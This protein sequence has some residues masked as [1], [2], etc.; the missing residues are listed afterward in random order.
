MA[1]TPPETT[2][3]IDLSSNDRRTAACLIAWDEA[4]R[5]RVVA[6][7]RSLT[8]DDLRERIRDAGCAGIDAPFSW[9]LRFREQ[10]A[11]HHEHG[12]WEA[13]YRD[14]EFQFR[15]TDLFV[16]GCA[17][18]PLSVSTN[19]I[20]VTAMRC[21]R[22]LEE[23]GEER[24]R[25]IE[26]TGADGIFEVYPAAALAAWGAKD[27]GFDPDGYKTGPKANEKRRALAEAIF[28]AADW[29]EVA[30]DV[31]ERCIRSDDELDALIAALATRA[32]ARDL[33]RPPETDSQRA[34]APVEGWIHVPQPGSFGRLPH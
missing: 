32:A 13:H 17:R 18:R 8:N 24:G 2:L 21:A 5:A 34:L 28:S 12:G 4:G 20:G 29:L 31:K 33:S 14:P 22:L 30:D 15:A 23:L 25:R 19:L 27:V 26:L 9:P 1:S 16:A 10:L 7:E 11:R 6:I 3:G